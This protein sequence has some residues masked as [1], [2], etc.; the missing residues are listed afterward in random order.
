MRLIIDGYSRD[1]KTLRDEDFL[2]IAQPQLS[3]G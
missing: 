1:P 2:W 3:I